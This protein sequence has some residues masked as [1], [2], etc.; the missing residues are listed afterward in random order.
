MKKIII[1]FGDQT[2][3]QAVVEQVLDQLNADYRVLQDHEL[4]QRVGT[5]VSYTHLDVYKRQALRNFHSLIDDHQKQSNQ[6]AAADKAKFLRKDCKDEIRLR[7]R[8]IEMLLHAVIKADTQ[9]SSRGNGKQRLNNLK[10]S[11][12]GILPWIDE[13]G[14]TG[15]TVGSGYNQAAQSGSTQHPHSYKIGKRR[16]GSQYHD[17][18]GT[19]HDHA[20]SKIRLQQN[21]AEAQHYKKGR[22]QQIPLKGLDTVSFCQKIRNINNDGN[23]EKLKM[24]IRDSPHHNAV[25]TR[26]A[27]YLFPLY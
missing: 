26:C 10:A 22:K 27:E 3:K 9:N 6:Q 14:D 16:I 1:Y 8:Q 23:F 21:Q 18:D 17:N 4:G 13:R 12:K 15:Q 7:L 19:D 11:T 5:P 2:D 24:C 20:A 25:N